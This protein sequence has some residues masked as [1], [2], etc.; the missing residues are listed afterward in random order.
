VG[1]I[2]YLDLGKGDAP[3]GVLLEQVIEEIHD[4]VTI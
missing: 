2:S 3:L 1:E 4:D